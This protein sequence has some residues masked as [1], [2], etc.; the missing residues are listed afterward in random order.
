MTDANEHYYILH[1]VQENIMTMIATSWQKLEFG[2]K[3]KP[4]NHIWK[5]HKNVNIL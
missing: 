3:C 1:R 2:Y 5:K 4:L